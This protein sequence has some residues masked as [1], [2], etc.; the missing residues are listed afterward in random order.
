MLHGTIYNTALRHGCNIV[1]NGCNIPSAV[2]CKKSS[3][4][5]VSCNITLIS[6]TT[7]LHVHYAYFTFLCRH[8]MP[9]RD[10]KIQ[11]EQERQKNNWFNSKTTILHVHHPS[12]YISFLFLHDY[13]VK[14]P[15]FAFYGGRKQATTKLYFSFWAWLWTLEIQLQEGSPTFDK[16]SG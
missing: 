6:K 3:L 16:V 10:F 7:T 14:M 15:N 12:L 11:R 13:E 8:F 2:L 9:Y 1:S 4:R 5:I